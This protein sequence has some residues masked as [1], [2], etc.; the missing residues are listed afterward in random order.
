MRGQTGE[1]WEEALLVN[2]CY[3]LCML[4]VYMC[5]YIH[6]PCS[7]LYYPAYQVQKPFKI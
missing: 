4:Y 7:C 1:G 6:F 3:I 2:I 5:I